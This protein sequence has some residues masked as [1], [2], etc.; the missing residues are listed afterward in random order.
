MAGH[1]I[2]D[3]QISGSSCGKNLKRMYLGKEVLKL[4]ENTGVKETE[5]L[6]SIIDGLL[7]KHS[8]DIATRFDSP[9][10]IGEIYS[11]AKKLYNSEI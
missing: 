8:T 1:P 3:Y 4:F 7:T 9:E 6:I 5:P 2:W 10:L 11:E